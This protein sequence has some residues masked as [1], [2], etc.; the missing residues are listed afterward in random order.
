M[1]QFTTPTH[2]FTLSMDLSLLKECHVIYAQHDK[3]LFVKTFE[4]IT[5]RSGNIITIHLSQDETG[6]FDERFPAQIQLHAVSNS[7]VVMASE[8]F[9]IEVQKL[10]ES[11]IEYES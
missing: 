6:L 4:D 3:V 7:D 2:T 8:I 10:L 1:Y 5:E 11:K 9:T